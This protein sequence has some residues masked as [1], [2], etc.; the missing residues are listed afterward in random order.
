MSE[1]A[2]FVVEMLGW[3]TV[4]VAY[5]SWITYGVIMAWRAM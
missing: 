1:R 5:G 3:F 4:S 2:R